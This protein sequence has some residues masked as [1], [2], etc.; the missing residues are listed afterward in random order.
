MSSTTLREFRGRQVI[1]LGCAA[2]GNAAARLWTAPGTSGGSGKALQSFGMTVH[3]IVFEPKPG[4]PTC[5]SRSSD[6][7]REMRDI[8]KLRKLER[9][10]REE[11]FF[12][13][14]ELA[15]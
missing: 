13:T 10:M 4:S 5:P 11:G 14:A 2:L 3:A 8:K 9:Y 6:K 1:Y 7:I 12:P 15:R